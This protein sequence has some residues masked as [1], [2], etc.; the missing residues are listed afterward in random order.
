MCFPRI[1]TYVLWRSISFLLQQFILVHQYIPIPFQFT[2]FK[3]TVTLFENTFQCQHQCNKS[4][5][6]QK[7]TDKHETFLGITL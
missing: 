2:I 4:E 1:V 6:T 5:S 3:G 7:E